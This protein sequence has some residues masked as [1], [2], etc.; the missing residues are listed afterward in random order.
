[1][2]ENQGDTNRRT[3]P[4]TAQGEYTFETFKGLV[5]MRENIVTVGAAV[6]PILRE[7]PERVAWLVQNLSGSDIRVRWNQEVAVGSGL[8]LA[9]NNG[10]IRSSI[11]QDGSLSSWALYGI[12][13][14]A[15]LSVYTL[16]VFRY[17]GRGG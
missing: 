17:T 3:V 9:A 5:T 7:N 2:A 16:E 11:T 6:V 4:R 14:L 1:M 15:G 13:P 12:G 10:L 8:L